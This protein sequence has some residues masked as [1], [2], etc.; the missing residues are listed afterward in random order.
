MT[1]HADPSIIARHFNSDKIKKQMLCKLI[2]EDT[3]VCAFNIIESD[4]R[5]NIA[6]ITQTPLND[7]FKNKLVF[8]QFDY[9]ADET[10]GIV[11]KVKRILLC[12]TDT[13]TKAVI[14]LTKKSEGENSNLMN[15]ISQTPLY[16]M[17]PNIVRYGNTRVEWFGKSGGMTISEM[18]ELA[19]SFMI[20]GINDKLMLM[21]ELQRNEVENLIEKILKRDK[22]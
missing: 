3:I 1:S 20:E 11:I 2:S 19:D 22:K 9:S 7:F 15:I 14:D 4:K 21:N 18:N 16:V 12:N 5:V 13:D 8:I 10:E 17:D 6:D